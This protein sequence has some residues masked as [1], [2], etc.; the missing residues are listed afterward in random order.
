MQCVY[1][2]YNSAPDVK[3]RI[4]IF[5]GLFLVHERSKMGEHAQQAVH[6]RPRA[7]A[8]SVLRASPSDFDS[9]HS[10]HTSHR[11]RRRQSLLY[12]SVWLTCRVACFSTGSLGSIEHA[13]PPENRR[14][15]ML[16]IKCKYELTAS[17]IALCGFQNR[18][19]FVVNIK[20][21]GRT[22]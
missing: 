18:P 19:K 15:P 9:A 3:P 20:M 6:R 7:Q 12:C 2:H 4:P 11:L 1:G 13:V 5:Q 16:D 22:N 14:T 8:R 10:Q 21:A 17:A